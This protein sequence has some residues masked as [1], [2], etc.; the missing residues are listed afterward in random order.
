MRRSLPMLL[1]LATAGVVFSQAPQWLP[2]SADGI[3]DPSSPAVGVLQE[4]A[5]A[6]SQ[7]PPDTVGNQVRWMQ[8][9]ESGAIA[10]RA[11]LLEAGELERRDTEVLMPRTGEMPMVKFP[12]RAHTQW[13]ACVNCHDELFERKAGATRVNMALILSGEKCG[14][15]HGAVAFPITECDRCHSVPRTIGPRP[16]G[17]AR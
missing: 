12:H 2:L 8:A 4:P 15:C 14:L 1:L 16:A 13:L 11:T 9:L 3:H 5:A 6:L 7:L 17:V 10:P